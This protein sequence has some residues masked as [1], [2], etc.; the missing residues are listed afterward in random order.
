LAGDLRKAKPNLHPH[1]HRQ[2]VH[3]LITV[4]LLHLTQQT[5]FLKIRIILVE[6]HSL[7]I[8]RENVLSMI[9]RLK[10]KYVLNAKGL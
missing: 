8:S 4:H 6:M 9:C 5:K 7:L 10:K 1:P 3:L 2:A